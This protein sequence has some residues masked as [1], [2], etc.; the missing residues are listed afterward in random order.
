MTLRFFYSFVSMALGLVLLGTAS[1]NSPKSEPPKIMP[2]G[3]SITA[4]WNQP[5]YRLFLAR[6]LEARN[7]KV[8]FVGNQV[9]TSHRSD[10]PTQF[11]GLHF[12]SFSAKTHPGYAPGE[13]WDPELTDDTDH[14][15]YPGAKAKDLL[16]VTLGEVRAAQPDYVLLHIGTNDVVKAFDVHTKDDYARFSIEVVRKIDQIVKSVFAGHKNPEKVM[17]LL[18]NMIPSD[19]RSEKKT[20][21]NEFQLSK[22]LTRYIEALVEG[23]SDPRLVKVDVSSGFEPTSMTTDGI[24]PNARGEKYIASAFLRSLIQVGLCD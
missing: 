12:P 2:L 14:A 4:G 6:Q 19:P 3:D 7:C 10:K 1:A 9:F 16:N 21:R 11:P 13:H 15:G 5:S 18:A 17:I 22:T 8:D 23:K 24:H 20:Y